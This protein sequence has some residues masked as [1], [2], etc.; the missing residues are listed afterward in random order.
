MKKRLI[1]LLILVC[2]IPVSIS[3]VC[4]YYLFQQKVLA[5][6]QTIGQSNVK[7]IELNVEELINKRMASLQL[8][9]SSHDIRSFDPVFGKR[10]LVEAFKIYPDMTL[11]LDD[12]SGMQKLRGD[13]LKVANVGSRQYFKDAINGQDAISDVLF[14]ANDNRQIVVLATPARNREGGEIIGVVQGSL[15][16]GEVDKFVENRSN[17]N[18][19]AYIIGR[20][21]KLLAHPDQTISRE[22][23]D[24]S[25]LAF[26]QAGMQGENGSAEYTDEQGQ[27]KIVN[28][29]KNAKTGWLICAEA[30]YNVVVAQINKLKLQIGMILVSTI[31]LVAMLGF[32]IAGR[33]VKPITELVAATTRVREGDLNVSLSI[34][35]T[36]EL[37]RLAENFNGMVAALR[38]LVEKV[39]AK[40]VTVASASQQ[41]SAGAE[42]S[43][44]ANQQ[45]ISSI[46]QVANGAEQQSK[47]VDATVENVEQT[48]DSIRQIDQNVGEV[49]HVSEQTAASAHAGETAIATAVGQMKNI[50]KTVTESA[51][52]VGELGRRSQEIG[53]FAET[54]SGIAGQTN[55]LALNAA[56]EAARAG[57]QGR[58]FAVVAEEVRKLA[59]QSQEAA[60]NIAQL[61][62]RIQTDTEA[63]V[64]AMDAGTREVAA[65]TEAVNHAG[66][67][68]N[69]I[70]RHING[71]TSQVEG[72]SVA[73]KQ[74]YS[75]SQDIISSIRKMDAVSKDAVAQAQMVSAATQ[76]Q[77]ASLQEIVSSSDMLM[78]MVGDLKNAVE[79]FKV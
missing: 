21:G 53:E 29:I 79:R 58:G 69:E 19:I 57:E 11:A 43:A 28:F 16:L 1:L 26:V 18:T 24:M 20:D 33:T 9:A 78:K 44:Q 73:V 7:T 31:L 46:T 54:I 39:Q 38:E 4:S 25:Q 30:P 64:A 41:L 34:R 23:K 40:A 62:S 61:I 56:I 52:V 74:V 59:E 51:A 8:L 50:E 68:F 3:S 17:E 37:G 10:H 35:D 67:T 12:H 66:S 5:D 42:Q 22:H 60:Q 48:V 76:E 55:L 45:V 72:I 2:A 6:F 32:F 63:A 77:S 15:T 13:D 47:V 65:G 36:T 27:R 71:L 70:V 14:S 49:T 75:G